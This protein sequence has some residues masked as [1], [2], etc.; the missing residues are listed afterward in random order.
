MRSVVA[1]SGYQPSH[2]AVFE[3]KKK[4]EFTDL[5]R[6]RRKKWSEVLG[7]FQPVVFFKNLFKVTN[8]VQSVDV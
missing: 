3:A 1:L 6:N 4:T 7:A 2:F 5:L 8:N